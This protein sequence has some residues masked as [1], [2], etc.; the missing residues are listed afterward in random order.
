V[1]PASGRFFII[2]PPGGVSVNWTVTPLDAAGH[3]VAFRAF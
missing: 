3:R 2:Q 1:L